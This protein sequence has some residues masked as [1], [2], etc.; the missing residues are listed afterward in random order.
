MIR[1]YLSYIWPITSKRVSSTVS[2]NLEVVWENGKKMLDSQGVNYSYGGLQKV[3]DFGL[4]TINFNPNA[5]F[6]LLGM[7]A[8]SVIQTLR[9]RYHYAGKITAVELDPEVIKIAAKEFGLYATPK[10]E[11]IE[12]DAREYVKASTSTFDL[13]IIDLFIGLK[14]PGVFFTPLFWN[15]L[16]HKVRKQGTILFNA[17]LDQ[18]TD[19]RIKCLEKEFSSRLNFKP[20]HYPKKANRLLV[21]TPKNI[22]F[23]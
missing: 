22:N 8:G 5:D 18:E 16:L 9:K 21:I 10:L 12:A 23:Q 1:K 20:L 14:V 2:G 13:I 17:G 11:I 4:S 3:L 19:L 7:G 6:L 15:N